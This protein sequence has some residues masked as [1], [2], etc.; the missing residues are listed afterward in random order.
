MVGEAIAGL[1][2]LKTA[3]DI[4]KGMKDLSDATKVNA[5]VIDLQQMILTAQMS[6]G[7][8]IEKARKLEAE[9]TALK[10]ERDELHRYQLV[11]VGDRLVYQLKKESARGEPIHYACPV[12]FKKGHI[13]ILQFSHSDGPSTWYE[14][15][16]CEKS[17]Y[18]GVIASSFNS[19]R[20]LD[21]D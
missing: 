7:E 16:A 4:A 10:R 11:Q 6:Q 14:C 20:I 5:A 21:D 18:L 3:F 1:S 12:C 19:L 15:H 2:A 9:V 13:S 17:H 8:L